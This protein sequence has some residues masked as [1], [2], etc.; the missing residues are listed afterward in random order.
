MATTEALKVLET[1]LNERIAN[2]K[3]KRN[4]DKLKATLLKMTSVFLAGLVTVLVGLQGENFD[5]TLLRNL[6]LAFGASITIVNAFDAFFDHRALWIKKTVTLVRLYALKRD[7]NFEV[8]KATPEEPSPLTLQ[9]YHERLGNILEDNLR[10]WMNLRAETETT[11]T[12]P[13]KKRSK[14]N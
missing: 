2:T 8:A 13:S 11:G 5:Q 9:G 12:S 10:E 7:L 4:R 1:Q 6:A 14:A 3:K